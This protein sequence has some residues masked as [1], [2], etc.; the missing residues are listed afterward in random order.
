MNNI[1]LGIDPGVATTG[2]GIIQVGQSNNL[3]HIDH[4]CILTKAKTPL[5]ERLHIIHN[6]LTDIIKKYKPSLVSVEELFFYK[7]VTTA[8]AVGQARGAILLTA[9]QHDLPLA[10]YTPLQVKQSVV[11]YGRAE[12][13]QVQTMVKMIL[14]MQEIA[15]PDDAADAL[16]VAICAANNIKTQ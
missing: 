15:K 11:G 10:E 14:G 1:I 7:N 13:Q 16:A 8:I 4:T 3:I 12:K 9:Q 6:E 2:I 5:S